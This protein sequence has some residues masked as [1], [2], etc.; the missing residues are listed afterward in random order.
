MGEIFFE[1]KQ[2]MGVAQGSVLSVMLFNIKINN[3]VKN[4]NSRTNSDLYV[5]DFLI[6]HIK[7]YG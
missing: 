6:C 1:E 7:L 2:E 5:N 4:I 3:I